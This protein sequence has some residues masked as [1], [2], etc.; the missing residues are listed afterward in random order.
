M[1]DR[2]AE[3]AAFLRSLK[4][5]TGRSY[6]ALAARLH[7][8]TSTLHRYCNGDA[9]P[10]EYA[11]VERFARL[12]AADTN[13]L[14]HLHRLWILAEA[15]RRDPGKPVA[16]RG[17]EPLTATSGEADAADAEPPSTHLSGVES[18]STNPSGPAAVGAIP[19][20]AD[21]D[22]SRT[23]P[24]TPTHPSK[25]TH[26]SEPA[27]TPAPATPSARPREKLRLRLAASSSTPPA[28]PRPRVPGASTPAV[29]TATGADGRPQRHW[30]GLVGGAVALAVF[31]ALTAT[32]LTGSRDE[33]S[34]RD[35]A[36]S[37]HAPQAV[38]N[39]RGTARA[40]AD[41]DTTSGTSASPSRTGGG[42]DG[43]GSEGTGESGREE[44]ASGGRDGTSRAAPLSMTTRSHVW[45]NGC[46][47]RYLVDRSPSRVPPPPVEQ[48]APTWAS[49]Q[50]AVHGATTNVEVTL[51]G[52]SSEAVVLQELHVRVVSRDRPLAWSSFAM[53]NG[54]G[55]ALTPAA[56]A[57]DLDASRP[58]ARPTD[59]Y[60]GVSDKP[61]P[62]VRLPYRVSAT[63]PL[64][65][66]VNARTAG[67]SCRWFLEL[68]WTS[69]GRKGTVR[70]DDG[71]RPF[72][73]SSVKGRPEYG[74]ALD[75]R[76][77]TRA[78]S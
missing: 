4:E 74:Y 54:C 45:E 13:E 62:A 47:H 59:G 36:A 40:V 66:L 11:P 76:T 43:K 15:A 77:W 41:D 7:V 10:A 18:P 27:P 2:V 73:T 32:H 67:C 35:V 31:A 57:V 9:V 55:G 34:P 68:D 64:V 75:T 3:F 61:L 72:R 12:C 71:G 1:P 56:F 39:P 78:P 52:T 38:T 69:R 22:A 60:D 21:S 53:E 51:Q 33:R 37:A 6:G 29:K 26:P 24:P 17:A 48:D 5:R 44:H 8:S 14:M 23:R 16:A 63:D 20:G 28:S 19:S 42:R 49:A 46:D 58:L 30:P 50:R 65:L 70:I 25:P